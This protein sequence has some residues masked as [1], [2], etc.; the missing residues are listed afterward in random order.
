MTDRGPLK[1]AAI[2]FLFGFLWILASD[3]LVVWFATSPEQIVRLQ[4]AKGW[5][6]VL[7]TTVLIYGLMRI[8][9]GRKDAAH[10]ETIRAGELLSQALEQK[11]LLV[12]ELHHRVKNNLQ[13]VLAFLNLADESEPPDAVRRRVYAMADTHEIAMAC[14]NPAAI[15]LEELLKRLVGTAARNPGQRAVV[16]TAGTA[17]GAGAEPRATL[18]VNQAIPLGLYVAEMLRWC[19]LNGASAGTDSVEVKLTT[20]E[21]EWH[22]EIQILLNSSP[23]SYPSATSRALCGA[24]ATQLGGRIEYSDTATI[25]SVPQRPIHELELED[26]GE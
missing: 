4:T 26:A 14:D 22:V 5:V 9:S 25:L 12:R 23:R 24:W 20:D 6:Y 15:D 16:T 17:A 7:L 2:Y 21:T 10:R 8:Y 13:T 1:I 19:E 11:K 3:T 18:T